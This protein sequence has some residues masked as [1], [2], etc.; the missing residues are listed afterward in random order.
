MSRSN[1]YVTVIDIGTTKIVAI[2]GRKNKAGKFEILGMGKS[3]SQG[4]RRGMVS[5]IEETAIAIKASVEQAQ[6][7]SG[8]KFTDVFVGIAGQHIKSVKNRGYKYIDD[9]IGEITQYDVD[10]LTQDMYKIPIHAGEEIIHVIPQNYIVDS[11]TGIRNPVGIS[12]RRLEANFHIVIGQVSSARNIT[13]CIHRVG[14]NLQKLILEPLASSSAVLTEDEKEAGVALLDIGGGTSD[15]AVY[16]DGIIRHT[17]VI[18][19]GGD[20]ITKDIQVGCSILH[21]HA[22]MLKVQ[23]GSAIGEIAPDDRVVTI[24]GIS[25]RDSKEISFKSLANIIQA[26]MEEIIDA[27]I[28]EIENTG[29]AE[30]LGA[31]IVIT[32][33][34]ALLRNLPQLVKYKTGLD[35]RIGYPNKYLS[36]NVNEQMNNPIYATGIGLLLKGYETIELEARPPEDEPQTEVEDSVE[37]PEEQ[38]VTKKSKSSIIET[39]RETMKGLFE[40]SKNDVKM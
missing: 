32:G 18:P 22:E 1:D 4:V 30:K 9:E 5:N 24:P 35:V 23:Y 15:I 8:I 21:R 19:F 33:G 7:C 25:G 3:V 6:E 10:M 29:F 11:E 17:G 38:T 34:G 14:L 26:R 37:Q 12:G 31:G 13:K 20:V 27:F 2:V 40:E 39:I 36:S 16:Y 28:F